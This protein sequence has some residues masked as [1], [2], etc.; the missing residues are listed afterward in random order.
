VHWRH[1]WQAASE[2]IRRTTAKNTEALR[3]A[4]G[5]PG[6]QKHRNLHGLQP[7]QWL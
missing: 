1:H 6:A 2:S 3:I 4:T 7:E 5:L